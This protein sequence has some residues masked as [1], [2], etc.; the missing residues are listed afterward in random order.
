ML[1]YLSSEP[2]IGDRIQPGNHYRVILLSWITLNRFYRPKSAK[3]T[4]LGWTLYV[5][6]NITCLM[7]SNL[8]YISHAEFFVYT[9]NLHDSCYYMQIS[10]VHVHFINRLKLWWILFCSFGMPR[11]YLHSPVNV[12]LH[13]ITSNCVVFIFRIK[14]WVLQIRLATEICDEIEGVGVIAIEMALEFSLLLLFTF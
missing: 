6:I 3:T 4:K 9:L 8:Y 11:M 5:I 7:T 10:I 2:L 14:C 13:V 1:S 12:F